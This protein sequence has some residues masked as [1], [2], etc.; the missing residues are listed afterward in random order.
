MTVK[1]DGEQAHINRYH[2]LVD[3]DKREPR[4]HYL[5]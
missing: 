5:F 2:I 4:F 1:M 3:S